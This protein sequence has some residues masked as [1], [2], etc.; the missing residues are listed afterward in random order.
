MGRVSAAHKQRF[1]V[2][3][4]FTGFAAGRK[5]PFK[6]LC[7]ETADG[8]REI[9]LK[10]SLQLMFFQ[11]LAVGDWVQIRGYQSLDAMTGLSRFK[12]D[13]IVKLAQPATSSSPLPSAPPGLQTAK[14]LV[15]Q[16]SAC[17][18][19]G[20]QAVCQALAAALSQTGL[21]HVQIQPTGCMNRCKAGPNVVVMPDKASYSQACP[22]KMATLVSHH[23]ATEQ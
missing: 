9:E 11:H 14:V 4:R 17:R 15:C 10:K 3:G 12:A 1:H 23:F 6:Y 18:Q 8:P 19:R 2:E 21:D 22:E 20:S 16:K 5:S 7:V 13:E